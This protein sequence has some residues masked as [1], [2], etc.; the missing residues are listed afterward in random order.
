MYLHLV[1]KFSMYFI[2]ISEQ[3]GVYFPPWPKKTNKQMV[4]WE[5]REELCIVLELGRH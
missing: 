4:F 2:L 5:K 1:L 3:K